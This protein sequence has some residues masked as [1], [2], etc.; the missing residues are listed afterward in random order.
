MEP[1]YLP[2]FL[3]GCCLGVWGGV[4]GSASS[5][6]HFGPLSD[7]GLRRTMALQGLL[8]LDFGRALVLL[9]NMIPATVCIGNGCAPSFLWSCPSR[10]WVCGN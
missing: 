7:H 6:L 9:V 1:V 10:L 4:F 2:P 5:G 8:M 3:V